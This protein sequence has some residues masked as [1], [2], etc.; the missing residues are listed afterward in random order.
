MISADRV[1]ERVTVD[2]TPSGGS[3]TFAVRPSAASRPGD[4]P[5][6]R[7]FAGALGLATRPDQPLSGAGARRDAPR[8]RGP[9]QAT[10]DRGGALASRRVPGRAAAALSPLLGASAPSRRA[11]TPDHDGQCLR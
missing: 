3:T 4:G 9:A 5:P 10:E 1:A 11:T 7:P 2:A 6:D 8:G